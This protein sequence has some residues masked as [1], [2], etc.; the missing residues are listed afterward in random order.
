MVTGTA[1]PHQTL[2]A[3]PRSSELVVSSQA[4]QGGHRYIDWNR[5]GLAETLMLQRAEAITDLVYERLL[6][7]GGISVEMQGRVH[8]LPEQVTTGHGEAN[9]QKL[10]QTQPL[11]PTTIR[12][13]TSARD[14]QPTLDYPAVV[15]PGHED[16]SSAVDGINEYLRSLNLA[17]LSEEER[18]YVEGAEP[19]SRLLLPETEA[20]D[21]HP[22]ET[23][24][25]KPKDK[26]SSRPQ[27]REANR[28]FKKS[29]LGPDGLEGLGLAASILGFVTFAAQLSSQA[30][31][32]Y[33]SPTNTRNVV[34]RLSRLLFQYSTLLHAAFE[35][36]RSSIPVGELQ[37]LGWQIV[38]DSQKTARDIEGFLR[39]VENPGGVVRTIGSMAMWVMW[40]DE[41]KGL[42]QELETLKTTLSAMLQIHQVEVMHMSISSGRG[43]R[44][45][46]RPAV[47]SGPPSTLSTLRQ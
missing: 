19:S 13:S 42:M 38:K 18:W 32:I 31:R 2:G 17:E 33:R 11:P 39:K 28:T 10:A 36:I 37:E 30:S 27:P 46:V 7:R 6:T 23:T 5:S 1:N 3:G 47:P 14:A 15:Q 26:A 8:T 45:Q 9:L 40:K 12:A 41:I 29:S 34:D 35:V 44:G 24:A 43:L 16:A 4:T 25:C 20:P 21:D 22:S